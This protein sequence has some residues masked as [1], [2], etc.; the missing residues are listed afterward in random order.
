LKLI[1]NYVTFSNSI[2]FLSENYSQSYAFF[3]KDESRIDKNFSNNNINKIMESDKESA[4]KTKLY[5]KN[6]REEIYKDNLEVFF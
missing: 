1:T 3:N 5:Y 4:I 2:A 6:N